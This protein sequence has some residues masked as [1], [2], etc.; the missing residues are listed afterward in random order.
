MPTC[1]AGFISQPVCIIWANHLSW[2]SATDRILPCVLH[3]ILS[4]D[5][6]TAKPFSHQLRPCHLLTRALPALIK[7]LA[8]FFRHLYMG[9]D[10]KRVDVLHPV[11]KSSRFV[12]LESAQKLFDKRIKT[13]RIRRKHSNNHTSKHWCWM[14][15]IIYNIDQ[16]CSRLHWKKTKTHFLLI[17]FN[18]W[19]LAT[20]ASEARL[21]RRVSHEIRLV[22]AAKCLLKPY[23]SK[24]V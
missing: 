16:T 6:L 3:R 12:I 2:R 24:R 11:G 8:I 21:L 20:H 17:A 14:Y 19:C 18:C 5:A 23:S 10:D 22:M 4:A 9:G 1:P 15:A 7:S 13:R